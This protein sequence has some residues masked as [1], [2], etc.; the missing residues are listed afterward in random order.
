ML[1]KEREVSP[2][3]N[4]KEQEFFDEEGTSMMR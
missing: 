1:R 4:H 3:E 2:P